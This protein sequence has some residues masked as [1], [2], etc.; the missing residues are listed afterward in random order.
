MGQRIDAAQ[1]GPCTYCN[2]TGKKIESRV[3]LRYS[4]ENGETE[5][6]DV[7]FKLSEGGVARNGNPIST[8]HDV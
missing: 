6:E 3:L 7:N 8:F 5:E 4:L 1:D 2:G